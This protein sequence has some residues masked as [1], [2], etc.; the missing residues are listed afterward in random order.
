M[1]CAS[2]CTLRVTGLSIRA[3]H[4]DHARRWAGTQLLIASLPDES[5]LELHVRRIAGGRMSGWLHDAACVGDR[6]RFLARR[7][8][9]STCQVKKISRCCWLAQGGRSCAAVRDSS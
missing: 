2:D 3:V 4:H 7:A 8:S 5:D 1:C 6:Y 9:V